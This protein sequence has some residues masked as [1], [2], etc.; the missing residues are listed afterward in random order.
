[1][2][3]RAGRSGALR[4]ADGFGVGFPLQRRRQHARGE[5]FTNDCELRSPFLAGSAAQR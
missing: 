3:D 5:T 1:M 2:R 4:N